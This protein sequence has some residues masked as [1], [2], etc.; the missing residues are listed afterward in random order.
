VH[1]RHLPTPTPSSPPKAGAGAD[2]K[3]RPSLVGFFG[4]A[5]WLVAAPLLLLS[6]VHPMAPDHDSVS[7]LAAGVATFAIPLAMLGSDRTHR[8]AAF[9]LA[10]MAVTVIVVTA[11]LSVF[12]ML[13]ASGR[14]S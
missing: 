8:F 12:V 1:T 11:V 14:V 10:G 7:V 2:A 5:A 6:L 13:V 4:G 3:R 9:M